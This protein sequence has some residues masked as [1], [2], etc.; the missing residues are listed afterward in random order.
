[1]NKENKKIKNEYI[2][3]KNQM[4]VCAYG[5]SEIRRLQELENEIAERGIEL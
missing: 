4:E 1:M 2:A 3:L 5:K